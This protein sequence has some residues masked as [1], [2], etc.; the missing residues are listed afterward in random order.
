MSPLIPDDPRR[1][2]PCMEPLFVTRRFPSA[3]KC[4]DRPAGCF[5]APSDFLGNMRAPLSAQL[6]PGGK[7]FESH[8]PDYLQGLGQSRYGLFATAP[9]RTLKRGFSAR[10]PTLALSIGS[11]APMTHYREMEPV[12]YTLIEISRST[13]EGAQNR[14][15]LPQAGGHRLGLRAIGLG[16]LNPVEPAKGLRAW[17]SFPFIL[18]A[19]VQE[20]LQDARVKGPTRLFP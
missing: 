9:G 2:L 15:R 13:R 18:A 12:L 8:E 14:F 4:S 5:M 19:E 11:V 1:P 20:H 10:V 6:R 16:A 17:G 3:L 7:V